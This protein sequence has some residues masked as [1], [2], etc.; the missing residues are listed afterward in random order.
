LP[1]PDLYF[2]E[3]YASSVGELVLIATPDGLAAILFVDDERDWQQDLPAHFSNAELQRDLHNADL[4]ATHRWLD[5][6]FAGEAVSPTDFEGRLDPAGTQF[7][8][9]VWQE[10]SRIPYGRTVSYG[11]IATRLGD[12]KRSRAVGLANGANPLPIL[13]P[14]HRVIGASGKLVGFGGGL[15]RKQKLLTLEMGGSLFNWD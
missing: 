7:Q 8:L 13:V 15:W 1:E 4:L 9:Q 3:L 6:Y 11:E 14:C 10:L 12:A 2:Y 5:R